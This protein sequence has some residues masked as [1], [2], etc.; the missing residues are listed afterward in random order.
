MYSLN[1]FGNYSAEM[2]RLEML[3][4]I[5]DP[6]ERLHFIRWDMFTPVLNKVFTKEKK[7]LV[8]DR[9]ILI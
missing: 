2:E 7:G 6:L 1:I 5:G 3:S 4:K 9:H 8:E